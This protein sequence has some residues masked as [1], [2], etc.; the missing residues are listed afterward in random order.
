VTDPDPDAVVLSGVASGVATLTLN[1]PERRNA[2]TPQMRDQFYDLALAA[3]RDPGVRVLLIRGSGESFCVGAD[4]DV[5]AGGEFRRFPARHDPPGLM[6]V[7]KPVVT[8]VQGACAGMGLILAMQSDV[9]FA[10]AGARVATGFA[11]LGLVAEHGLSWLMP[12]LLGWPLAVDLLLSGRVLAG[13]ELAGSGFASCTVAEADLA[14]TAAAYARCIAQR[15][16]PWSTMT[17]KAQIR[18]HLTSGYEDAVRESA[19][20]TELALARPDHA[21]GIEA[22]R[23]KRPPEFLAPGSQL[24]LADLERDSIS[25]SHDA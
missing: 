17:M 9:R 24:P 7:R 5:V 18:R 3:D 11:T 10:A 12:R 14:D 25:T 2:W 8:A 20:L 6:E 15:C 13:E 1:R 22:F 4:L 16:S 19:A 23:K 21:I